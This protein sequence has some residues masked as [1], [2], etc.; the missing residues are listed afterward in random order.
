[1][2][3]A[4]KTV[5]RIALLAAALVGCLGCG[6]G[7]NLEKTVSVSGTVM[8]DNQPMSEGDITFA[9][10]TDGSLDN[11]PVKEG[12]FSGQATVGDRRVEI[13]AFMPD[14]A[15]AEM[16]KDDPSQ[17]PKVNYLPEKYNSASS[18]KASVTADGPN[19]FDFKVTSS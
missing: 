13:R 5:I 14:P 4:Q 18:L 8:L 6:G 17:A 15:N 1:M 10:T 16:Y 19:T 12:K 7:V 3:H 2:L 11:I 9:S